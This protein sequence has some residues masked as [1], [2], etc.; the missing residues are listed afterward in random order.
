[1]KTAAFFYSAIF[2]SSWNRKRWMLEKDTW[3]SFI[4]I[5]FRGWCIPLPK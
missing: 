3:I 1:M 2:F 5:Y 4:W